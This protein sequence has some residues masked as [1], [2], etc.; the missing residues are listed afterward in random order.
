MRRAKDTKI[1]DIFVAGIFLGAVFGAQILAF[2]D[3]EDDGGFVVSLYLGMKKRRPGVFRRFT[4][5]SRDP[6][7][8]RG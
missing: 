7:I 3:E 1:G 5:F 2:F 4:R 6:R 8:M